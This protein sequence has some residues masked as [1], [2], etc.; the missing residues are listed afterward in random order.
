MQEKLDRTMNIIHR[1]IVLLGMM[2][3]GKS[4]VGRLLAQRLGRD[5]MDSDTLIEADQGMAISE[6]FKQKGEAQ[7]RVLE[8]EKILSLLKSDE[9]AVIATGGGAVTTSE[10]M[11]AVKEQAVSIWL[12]ADCKTLFDRIASDTGRPLL[13]VDDPLK[14]LETLLGQRKHLYAQADITVDVTEKSPEDIVENICAALPRFC[15]IE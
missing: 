3:A 15:D 13:Q 10:V 5:F 1:S 12:S 6:I 9:P 4:Y 11:K 14:R 2:G 7:F 8:R